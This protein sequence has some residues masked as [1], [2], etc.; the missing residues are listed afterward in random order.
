LSDEALARRIAQ[1]LFDGS[2]TGARVVELGPGQGAL[3]RPLL[4]LFPQMAAFEIDQRMVELLHRE[5][6][7]LTVTHADLLEL[8]FAELAAEYGGS[9]SIVSN[10]PFYLTS[11][12][13]Y[14]LLCAAEHID[15]VV[16]TVQ[17]EVAQKLLSPHGCKEYGILSVM[18]QLFGQ[19]EF[20]FDIPPTAFQPQPKCTV[21]VLRLRPTTTPA[22]S[23]ATPL[24]AAQ[25][26]QL[27]ALLKVAFEQRRKMLRQTLKPLLSSGSTSAPPPEWL[28]LRPE[29]LSPTQF[30][31][32]AATIFGDGASGGGDTLLAATHSAPGWKPYKSGWDAS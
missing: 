28:T 8:D 26:S 6:P 27:L 25:R 12:L 7:D 16:L 31:E 24:S 30:V 32:L 9:L 1:E 29:Q 2:E 13:L 18:V 22:V 17:S 11:Q 15:C 21:A 23:G 4:S 20:L 19:P 3:T 14:K 5:F 10:T